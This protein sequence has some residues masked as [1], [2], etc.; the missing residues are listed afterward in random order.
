MKA[1]SR[2]APGPAGQAEPAAGLGR[3]QR[4]ELYYYARLTRDVEER[5]SVLHRQGKVIG[6]V[7]RSLGQ[8][9]ESVAT[10][11]ALDRRTDALSPLTRNLG[12]LMAIGVRPLEMYRQYMGKATSAARGRD[13]SN[14]FAHLPA[15]GEAGPV[16]VGPVSPLGDMLAVMGGITLAAKLTGRP[17]VGMVYIGDGGTSTGVFHE[18]MNF[19]A[20]KRLP[21]VVIA[22]D[23]KFAYSTP[24]RDQ[25][26]IDRIDRRAEAYGM[27]HELVDG[28]DMLAV[29]EAA[30]RAVDRARE[31]GGPTLVGIDTMRMKGHAAHDDMRYV[32]PALVAEWT[33]R[34]PIARC[35][36]RLLDDGIATAGEL[37][38]I[39]AKT[40][41]YADTEAGI[42]DG[43]PAADP[44]TVAR[45]LFAPGFVPTHVELVAPPQ[46]TTVQ[47]KSQTIQ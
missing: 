18:A 26:A 28:N 44:E 22:E 41:A 17:L 47:T 37:D 40:K 35:R 11:Y 4:L 42:A 2:Q 34:D 29:Y 8:E 46:F 32:E 25:M 16:I 20:V 30:K 19:A 43:E 3:Q 27:P 36:Q 7:Y 12:A 5:V 14:H 6:A 33:A 38:A 9:G 1:T 15:P 21:M 23:N 24:V 39:D 13:L 10:A 31:G 45:G